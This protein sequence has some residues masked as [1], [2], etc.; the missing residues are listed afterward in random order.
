MTL[1]PYDADRLDQMAL[2]V[3]DIAA[4]IRQMAG[5]LRLEPEIELAIHDRKSAEWLANLERWAAESQAKLEMARIK[6]RGVKRAATF[7]AIK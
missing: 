1:E 6:N 2:R 5:V 4:A 3:L 7:S